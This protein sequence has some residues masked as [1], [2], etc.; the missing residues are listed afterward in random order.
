[1]RQGYNEASYRQLAA[2]IARRMTANPR[3]I[4]SISRRRVSDGPVTPSPPLALSVPMEAKNAAGMVNAKML[5]RFQYSF[6]IMRTSATNPTI[7]RVLF[8]SVRSGCSRCSRKPR[9]C[10]R[11][12]LPGMS[13]RCRRT[14][15]RM[16]SYENAARSRKAK[17]SPTIVDCRSLSLR[18]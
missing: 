16:S 10:M 5:P 15:P 9:P 3:L 1:M 18:K 4:W 13:S 14:T 7:R 2:Y 12:L 8:N 11:K 17:H 6:T